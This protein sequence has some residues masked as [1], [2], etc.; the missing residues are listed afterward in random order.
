MSK[1]LFRF[2]PLMF[3]KSIDEWAS[4]KDLECIWEATFPQILSFLEP[5]QEKALSLHSPVFVTKLLELNIMFDPNPLG[6]FTAKNTAA[7]DF[8]F[9]IGYD[10]NFMWNRRTALTVASNIHVTRA[11]IDNGANTFALLE[12][13]PAPHPK[14]LRWTMQYVKDF[15]IPAEFCLEQ[16]TMKLEYVRLLYDFDIYI[17]Q[18][19]MHLYDLETQCALYTFGYIKILPSQFIEDTSWFEWNIRTHR[20]YSRDQR[21]FVFFILLVFKRICRVIPREMRLMILDWAMNT[22]APEEYKR[23]EWDCQKERRDLRNFR[24]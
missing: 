23:K 3:I 13:D 1:E 14:I 15:R 11:L 2:N 21:Q 4:S 24:N 9:Q 19:L 18:N 17:P 6:L 8:F 5:L 22:E 10:V 7:V 16:K 20:F 12:C